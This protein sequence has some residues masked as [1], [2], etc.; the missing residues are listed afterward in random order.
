[1]KLDISVSSEKIHTEVGSA[2]NYINSTS[3][4]L[5]TNEALLEYDVFNSSYS[6]L[7]YCGPALEEFGNAIQKL[8]IYA[9][10][11]TG[12]IGL[13]LLISTLAIFMRKEMRTAT[14]VILVGIVFTAW[15][16]TNLIDILKDVLNMETIF[17]V[18]NAN[19]EAT[20]RTFAEKGFAVS[21]SDIHLQ[22]FVLKPN[23]LWLNSVVMKLL[24]CTLITLMSLLTIYSLLQ[25]EK[26]R[27]QLFGKLNVV[28]A[29]AGNSRNRKSKDWTILKNIA[30][31]VLFLVVE[32]PQGVLGIVTVS[33]GNSFFKSCYMPLEHIFVFFSIIVPVTRYMLCCT[34]GIKFRKT[35]AQQYLI[36]WTRDTCKQCGEIWKISLEPTVTNTS[37]PINGS[38]V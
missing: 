36:K 5:D 12:L 32:F 24:P 4:I 16:S 33:Q 22:N 38:Q 28:Q 6:N 20:L 26:R 9:N 37:S 7:E 17:A 31:L 18:S 34:M 1:M 2:K 11:L 13:A 21:V 35:F 15:F 10:L 27:K 23:D 29:T 25:L 8:Q 14:N 30:I 3:N 19:G